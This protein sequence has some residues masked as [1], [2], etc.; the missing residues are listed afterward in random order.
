MTCIV[1]L[2]HDGKVYVGG[3]AAGTQGWSMHYVRHPTPKVWEKDDMIFGL[4]GSPREAQIIR[5]LAHFSRCH[6][7]MDGTEYMIGVV[8]EG[9]REALRSHGA[10]Q[11]ENNVE[12]MQSNLLIA[13]RD[14]V[15]EVETNFSVL[16]SDQ[17]YTAIGAG[18]D[19]ALGSLHASA[20][21]LD[22]TQRVTKALEAAAA[23][24]A[25][26]RPPFTIKMLGVN[27]HVA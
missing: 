5:H 6:P 10:L 8:A 26:V 2:Q 24:N 7:D 13:F 18:R 15:Y 4:A 9:I 12:T 25:S 19:Y 23:F 14:Q 21:D 17:P 1:A 22:P 20:P 16:Q 27:K 3:D 11:I